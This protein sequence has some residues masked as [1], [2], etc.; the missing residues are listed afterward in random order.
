MSM[1][2]GKT[3]QYETIHIELEK[4]KIE[5]GNIVV[6]KFPKYYTTP[7]NRDLLIQMSQL[8][9][10]IQKQYKDNKVIVMT[11]ECNISNLNEEMMNNWGWYKK[12]V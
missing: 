10:G 5:P 1:D 6:V 8:S 11:D 9:M 4:L 7:Q 2:D 3:C 12:D